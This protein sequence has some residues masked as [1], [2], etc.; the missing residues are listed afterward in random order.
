MSSLPTYR[1]IL[2]PLDYA[3]C[4][5][6]VA[7]HAAGMARAFGARMTLLHV[8]PLPTGDT[9]SQERAIEE[10]ALSELGGLRTVLDP[11]TEVSLDVRHG[12]PAIGI[13][14]AIEQHGADLVVMGTHAR[15]GLR[16]LVL[17]SVA[18]Q[19]IRKA[20]VPVLVIRGPGSV[21]DRTSD[22]VRRAIT[23]SAG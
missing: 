1:H 15:E 5:Y 19:V 16:R 12:L 20:H 22:A 21:T 13:C 11:E 23:E 4:A 6:D 9:P 3:G 7:Q 17:G 14:D 8:V 2:V 10:E 18:E